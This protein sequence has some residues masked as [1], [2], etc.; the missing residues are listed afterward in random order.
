MKVYI[1]IKTMKGMMWVVFNPIWLKWL[2][3]DEDG[4]LTILKKNTPKD[5]R[6]KYEAL[7]KEEQENIK[8]GKLK[9]TI[10]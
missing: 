9:K 10:F 2:E 5:I 8:N 3:E 4:N 7:L 6:K 1:I